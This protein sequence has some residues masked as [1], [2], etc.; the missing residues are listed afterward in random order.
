MPVQPVHRGE[1]FVAVLAHQRLLGRLVKLHMGTEQSAAFEGFGTA[2][3]VV[4]ERWHL[5]GWWP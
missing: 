1:L 4:N 2:A 5:G 3:T